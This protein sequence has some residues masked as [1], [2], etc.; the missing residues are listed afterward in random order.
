MDPVNRTRTT[1]LPLQQEGPQGTRRGSSAFLN[2]IQT[3]RALAIKLLVTVVVVVLVGAAIAI[4]YT[5]RSNA[6]SAALADAMQV[7]DTPVST[8]DQPLPPSTKSFGSTAERARAAASQFGAIAQKYGMTPAGRNALYLQAVTTLDAG[9]KAAAEPLLK[10]SA[11]SSN[12]DVA[13]LSAMALAGL[14][15]DTGR[16]TQAI[17]TYKKVASKPSVLVPAGLARLNLAALYE[18]DGKPAEAKKLYAEIKDKDPKSAA[19]EI[20]TQKLSGAP[21]Q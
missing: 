1:P 16:D 5:L 15:H 10:K 7:L 19:A 2:R 20:A 6:A 13:T 18:S 14:Y 21:A 12:R 3:D 9:D 11:D 8:P 17:D 4:T